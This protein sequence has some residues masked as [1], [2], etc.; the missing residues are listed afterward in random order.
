MHP[1]GR[2]AARGCG[3]GVR[4]VSEE[5]GDSATVRDPSGDD[6]PGESVKRREELAQRVRE[7]NHLSV[8]WPR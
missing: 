2:A 8:H 7:A 6:E 3:A 4:P 5:K 1:G